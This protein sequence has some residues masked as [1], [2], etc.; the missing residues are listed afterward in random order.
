MM[1]P[2]RNSQQRSTQRNFNPNLFVSTIPSTP[3]DDKP[4][5]QPPSHHPSGS[6]SP[7]IQDDSRICV[8]Q[9]APQVR[10]PSKKTNNEAKFGKGSRQ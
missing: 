1:A 7:H 4:A 6:S 3:S 9:P 8:V 5:C 2:A 10:N